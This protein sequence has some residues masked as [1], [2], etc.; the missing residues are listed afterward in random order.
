[1][2][3]RAKTGCT[4]I[5]ILSVHIKRPAWSFAFRNWVESDFVAVRTEIYGKMAAG[6]M[7]LI[8]YLLFFFNLIFWV[9][10]SYFFVS[11]ACNSGDKKLYFELRI[12]FPSTSAACGYVRGFISRKTVRTLVFRLQTSM[13]SICPGIKRKFVLFGTTWKEQFALACSVSRALK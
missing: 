8:K 5:I 4:E 9:S 11:W 13:Y 6:G 7:I 3:S 12:N 10:R 2:T 1:M